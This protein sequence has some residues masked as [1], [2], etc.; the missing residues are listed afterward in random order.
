MPVDPAMA[1]G[2]GAA[3]LRVLHLGKYY[4][5]VRGGIERHVQDLAE[6]GAAA[7]DHTGV[8][9]HQAAGRW[10][11]SRETLNQVSLWRAGCVAAPVYTPISPGFPA[12]L[13][14]AIGELEPQLLHLHLPNPSCLAALGLPAARRLPWL[15]HWHADVPPDTPDWRLRAAYRVYR[16]FE[17]ALLARAAAIIATSDDYRRASL[18]LAPWAGKTRIVPLGSRAAARAEPQPELWP[19]GGLRLLSAGR[20]SRYKG[21]HVLLEALAGLPDASLLLI[22]EGECAAG[23]RAT[24]ARLQLGH[25][26]RFAGAVDDATLAAARAAADVFVLPSLDRGEAFGLTLLEA[27][28]AGI[29]VVASRIPG[30]GVASVVGESGL[31]VAPG[32]AGALAAALGRL[33]DPAL[34]RHLGAAGR[35]RWQQHFTLGQCIAATRAIQ[36]EVVARHRAAAPGRG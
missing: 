32:D 26:V 31:L 7:G 25:R 27:M 6:G 33:Q 34:R 4:A 14:R 20:L 23:L 30:S 9:V 36:R 8:L 24:A 11:R 13:H 15:V 21:V 18:A 29:A 28:Q 3:P 35:A 22:G 17:R 5:P 19:A 1:A 2:A 16:H 10:R 12:L